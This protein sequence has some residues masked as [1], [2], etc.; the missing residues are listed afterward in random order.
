MLLT[1]LT[2]RLVNH[3]PPQ[4]VTEGYAGVDEQH[5]ASRRDPPPNAHARAG[6]PSPCRCTPGRATALPGRH[7][8]RL[9]HRV[10][11]A[12]VARRVRRAGDQHRVRVSRLCRAEMELEL[13]HFVA[14]ESEAGV[15]SHPISSNLL[16]LPEPPRAP[17]SL[18]GTCAPGCL[19]RSRIRSLHT[20]P[21]GARTPLRRHPR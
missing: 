20:T 9:A 18:R 11:E 21:C 4:D 19:R 10:V 5:P 16:A 12:A 14:A 6:R 3:A 15:V 1:S 8:H 2:K 17:A 13:A 7:R